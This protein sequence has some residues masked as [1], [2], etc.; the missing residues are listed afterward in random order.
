[1][2]LDNLAHFKSLDSQNFIREIDTL[3]DQVTAGWRLSQL[4]RLP[5]NHGAINNIIITGMGGSA[6]G[7]ALVQALAAPECRVP[8]TLW[9]DYNLPAFAG[10]NTLVICSSHSGDTEETLSSFE[11]ALT[12]G[13]KLL[14]ITT[15]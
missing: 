3:P 5:N 15:G 13:A 4:F 7:G 12:R 1:M 6:I 14:V 11:A 8:I 10:L 9:R 2:D